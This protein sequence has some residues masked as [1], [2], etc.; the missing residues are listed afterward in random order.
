MEMSSRPPIHPIVFWVN[1]PEQD[2]PVFSS[3]GKVFNQLIKIPFF[4]HW[5][6]SWLVPAMIFTLISPI[7]AIIWF[8][9]ALIVSGFVL[10]RLNK[11]KTIHRDVL[12]VQERACTTTSASTIGSAIHVAGHPLLERD[13]PVVLALI[14]DHLSIFKY[15]SDQPVDVIFLK[16]ITNLYTVVYDDER[17]PHIEVIDSAAQALQISITKQGQPVT[18]SLR[19][20]RKV[21]PIDWYHAIEKASYALGIR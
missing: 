7:L 3:Q 13:Q 17:V 8:A 1:D 5:I 19:S 16:D 20:M 2:K 6:F 11:I 10:F 15:E 9:F 12:E 18:F 14:D 21:R 4:I